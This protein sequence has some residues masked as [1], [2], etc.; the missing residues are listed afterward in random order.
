MKLSVLVKSVLIVSVIAIV[1]LGSFAF[2]LDLVAQVAVKSFDALTKAIPNKVAFDA[3]KGGWAITGLDNKERIILSKD[4]SS[5]RSDMVLEFDAAPFLAAGLNVAKL[6]VG[7]YIYDQSTGKMSMPF[8]FGKEKFNAGAK[9]SIL[10]TFKEIVNFHRSSIGYHEKLD[11]YGITM[12]DGNMLEWAKDM[13]TNDKDLVFVL[14]PK[15]FIKAGVNPAQLKE[16]IFAKVPV[17]D[18]SG[19]PI[20]VEKFLKPFNVK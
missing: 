6:P 15:P 16:W 17:K 11:H 8:D 19:R 12:G 18:K 3:Q 2:S 1:S 20:E 10:N 13:S 5:S 14:N 4:F 9:Q 7:Q